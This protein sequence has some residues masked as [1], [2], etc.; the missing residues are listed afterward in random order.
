MIGLIQPARRER[1]DMSVRGSD[2]ISRAAAED[3]LS[4]GQDGHVA[5]GLADVFHNVGGKDHRPVG[6][7][8]DQQ[9]AEADALLGVE[10]AVGSSTMSR[11]GSLTS[12][13]AMP[14]RRVLRPPENPLILRPAASSSPT[15]FNTSSTRRERSRVVHSFQ[16]CHV[17]HELAGGQ[18]RVEAE[19]LGEVAER[20]FDRLLA[21]FGG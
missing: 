4:V 21:F 13:W 2:Q 12:A 16:D 10:A 1:P 17:V 9:V 15:I 20:G 18:L 7:Q 5:A 8:V 14:T 6:C 11:L 3:D 19:L